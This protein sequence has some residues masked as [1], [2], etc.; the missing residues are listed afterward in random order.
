MLAK[1]YSIY[2]NEYKSCEKNGDGH[3]VMLSGDDYD[4]VEGRHYYRYGCIKC[5]L[6]TGALGYDGERYDFPHSPMAH[7]FKD[8]QLIGKLHGL[9]FLNSSTKSLEEK[10]WVAVELFKKIDPTTPND[11]IEE[12]MKEAFKR[13]RSRD[14]GSKNKKDTSA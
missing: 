14:K 5:Q 13:Q 9:N 12:K 2:D 1:Y 7:Y 4:R 8:N 10:F 6:N 3:Y 11:E